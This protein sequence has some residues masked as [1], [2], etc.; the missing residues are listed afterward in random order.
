MSLIGVGNIKPE[1]IPVN[2]K[3]ILI[4]SAEI[5]HLLYN[6]DR[7]FRKLFKIKGRF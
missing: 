5:Y 6:L 4:G 3:V 7:D 1:P 2:V